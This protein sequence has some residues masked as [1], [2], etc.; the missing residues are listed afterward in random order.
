MVRSAWQAVS[1]GDSVAGSTT[2]R[3][4]ADSFS[5]T[6]PSSASSLEEK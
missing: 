3:W 4:T 5:G 2:S 1:K 6:L